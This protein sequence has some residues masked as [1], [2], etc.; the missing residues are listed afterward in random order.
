MLASISMLENARKPFAP[1][2]FVG[3]L[4]DYLTYVLHCDVRLTQWDGAKRLPNFIAR[5]YSLFTGSILQQP[6]LFAIDLNPGDD[7]PAQITKQ[8]AMMEREFPGVVVYTTEHLTANRRARF[9]ASGIAFAVPGNQ[10]YIPAL[11]IDLREI[12]RRP[13]RRSLE[14]LSPVAQA[15]FFYCI[16]F[17]RELETDSNT[18]TPSRMAKSLGYS[19]MSVG[20]AYDELSESGLATVANKGRQRFL[21][22]DKDSRL[23]LEE[24]RELLRSPVQS[25]RF[26]R[27]RL[28]IPPM[29]I[30]GESALS[31]ITG[32]SPPQTP[33]YA[34]HGDDWKT[35]LASDVEEVESRDQADATIEI[36]HYRPNILS[37]YATVD[38]L[39][40]Y[41]QFW[42]HPNERIAKAADDALEHVPW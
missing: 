27:C 24:S 3:Q 38:P 6:C 16:L 26:A 25:E 8:I 19:A 35:L 7:T 32:L 13:R 34:L 28:I 5:R 15:T 42:N 4:R 31:N 21:S 30:A 10:L 40:L 29:K 11:A 18:R 41:A 22:L 14:H 39:S 17:R 37:E 20:R 1:E 33:V 12:F 36:W 23:L 2:G 9:I